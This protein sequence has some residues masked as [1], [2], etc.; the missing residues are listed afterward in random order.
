VICAVRRAG[1]A[2][3]SAVAGL[4]AATVLVALI[5]GT[6]WLMWHVTGW[7]LPRQ[8][9]TLA[10]LEAGIAGQ[11]SAR[12]ILALVTCAG[13]VIWL[14]FVAEVGL[15]AA[16]WARQLPALARGP[17][18]RPGAAWLRE[19]AA[20]V[21]PPRAV[22]TILVG[23]ILLGLLAALRGTGAAL[24]IPAA[25]RLAAVSQQATAAAPPHPAREGDRFAVLLARTAAAASSNAAASGQAPAGA[26]AGTALAAGRMIR[27]DASQRPGQDQPAGPAYRLYTVQPGDNLWDI[28][29]THLGNG[30]DWHQIYA[31]NAGLP[32]PD[33]ERLVLPSLI[34]PGWILRLPA[35]ASA[36]N[37][38]GHLTSPSA[39]VTP[40]AGHTPPPGPEPSA[41]PQRPAPNSLSPAP[42]RHH[43]QPDAGNAVSIPWGGLI[44]AGLAGAVTGA[45]TL[46]GVQ[47]RRRYQPAR[48]ITPS[49]EP[50]A[51]VPPLIGVLHRAA[52]PAD[53]Q[54]EQDASL[55]AEDVANGAAPSAATAGGRP[56]LLA[57]RTPTA[58]AQA[59][60]VVSLGLRDGQEIT[61]DIAGLGGLGLTGPGAAAAARA[62]LLTLLSQAQ[63]G[64]GA[65]P[66]EV[67]VP[68][69]DAA[70]LIPGSDPA[71]QPGLTITGTLSAALDHL[72]AA[73]LTRVRIT[74]GTDASDP[75][76]E[77][78]APSPV[79][80]AA[81][82]AT[83]DLACSPR[84]A[85]ILRM[86]QG[87][88]VV[89]ILL[90]DWPD[91]V[92]CHA[93][94]DGTVTA[95]VP[96]HPDF[97]GLQ[98]F[99]LT[100]P[101][102]AAILSAFREAHGGSELQPQEESAAAADGQPASGAAESRGVADAGDPAT[103]MP[104]E[105]A[106]SAPE[107]AGAQDDL[108]A[109]RL[110]SG[111][112]ACVTL[113]GPPQITVAGREIT[114]GLR[115]ARE[116]LAFLAVHP[117]GAT[118]DQVSEALWPGAPPGHGTAQRNIAVRKLREMLRNATGLREAMFIT[119]TA[120]RYR[121]DAA[122]FDIDIWRFQ[123]ALLEAR[124]AE[125]E[126]AQLA[127]CMDAVA[128]YHGP[129]ADGTGYDWA[130]PYAEQARRRAL[131]AWTRIAEITAPRDPEQALAALETALGHDP[132]NEFVYQKI[133]RLQAA[134]DRPDA[135]RR[136][137]TLL[138][139]RLTELGVT[140]GP[141]TRSLAASLL[142]TSTDS[143]SRNPAPHGSTSG[144]ARSW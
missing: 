128:A 68:A 96:A 86:G 112:A 119:L 49:L 89:A 106:A 26:A 28:A 9:P 40:A 118:G 92:T 72:E 138:E 88:G 16:W 83:P 80:A 129:L 32:Q 35:P 6:P 27:L 15:E 101:D 55:K 103:T 17:A 54:A 73:V 46:A 5:A 87:R 10:T 123:R 94:A 25:P 12:F 100:L 11:E 82:I 47:R 139:T 14:V 18:G 50:G 59:P 90:G 65:I 51:P 110:P 120:D 48:I 76:A 67:F 66:A 115:K 114:G 44:G 75:E 36:P 13:W 140:P 81:L 142:G 57:A 43:T 52:R 105:D 42:A 38:N 20:A 8:L 127:A 39:P 122:L 33:G 133:M 1:H 143:A 132:Y 61:A 111:A 125:G 108:G 29:L 78:T 62:L 109:Q 141:Q 85:A 4:A 70:M 19:R 74:A 71:G 135:V 97:R 3:V 131:D 34:Q 60:G 53:T 95:A 107:P 130:E 22:A 84:L 134:A 99:H 7:P 104:D 93:D 56:Y 79:C 31:L 77:E 117:D 69:A 136:T 24:T 21:S 37:G 144:H 30:E 63:P 98:L 137:L 121:L 58:P 2:V 91:G 124:H 41:A 45:L 126:D 113:L 102:A 64:A 23:G 116:M